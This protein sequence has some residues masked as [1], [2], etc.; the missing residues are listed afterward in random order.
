MTNWGPVCGL[1]M[2]H[3]VLTGRRNPVHHRPLSP[4]RA[5]AP[6]GL[7]AAAEEHLA[8]A[9]AWGTEEVLSARGRVGGKR[10]VLWLMRT[11]HGCDGE[12]VSVTRKG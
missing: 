7:Q 12:M 8:V 3:N 11:E 5:S 10:A 6:G 1:H 2:Y 4:P 9:P